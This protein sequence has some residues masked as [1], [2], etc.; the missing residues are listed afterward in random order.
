MIGARAKLHIFYFHVVWLLAKVFQADVFFLF[1][2][3]WVGVESGELVGL[4]VVR[5][6]VLV[7]LRVVC[8][9]RVI[10]GHWTST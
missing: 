5:F 10:N 1:L 7:V 8:D 2:F 3:L 6:V 9:V 4:C